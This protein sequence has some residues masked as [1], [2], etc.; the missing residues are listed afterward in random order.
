[1]FGSPETVNL[2]LSE[3]VQ[4]LTRLCGQ[5]DAQLCILNARCTLVDELVELRAQE[6][7]DE[8]AAKTQDLQDQLNIMTG[9]CT[10]QKS[11]INKLQETQKDLINYLEVLDKTVRKHV[12]K[13]DVYLDKRVDKRIIF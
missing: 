6:I 9:R 11:E 12:P 4:N 3:K 13:A 8:N 5:Y 2:V 10:S 1:V 7:R